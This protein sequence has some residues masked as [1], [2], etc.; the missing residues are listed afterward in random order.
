MKKN[1]VTEIVIATILIISLASSYKYYIA[2]KKNQSKNT[3]Y[4]STSNDIASDS[5]D[6]LV[7]LE[8]EDFIKTQ[9]K[10][11]N[12]PLILYGSSKNEGIMKE[13]TTDHFEFEFSNFRV[14]DKIPVEFLREESLTCIS[15]YNEDGSLKKENTCIAKVDFKITNLNNET[16][17]TSITG[18]QCYHVNEQGEDIKSGTNKG[19]IFFGSNKGKVDFTKNDWF[20]KLGAAEAYSDTVYFIIDKPT[21]ESG[22]LV[23]QVDPLGMRQF[24]FDN[25]KKKYIKNNAYG[26]IKVNYTDIIKE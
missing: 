11:F 21:E 17:V 2:D 19:N 7:E 10:G 16:A 22:N 5:K 24:H 13:H 20:P 15:A 9:I 25:I 3:S 12:E 8:D 18:F 26:Y 1:R 14:F 6:M 23:I 4:E